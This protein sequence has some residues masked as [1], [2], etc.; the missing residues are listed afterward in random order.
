MRPRELVIGQTVLGRAIGALHFARP[1]Y[2]RPK[3]A[4][5]LFGAIHGD[6]PLGVLPCT[7]LTQMEQR[8]MREGDDLD[9]LVSGRI[10]SYRG[11]GYVLPTLMQ[12]VPRGGI[13][14][15]Q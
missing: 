13:N 15:L 2:A 6:E 7:L 3:P 11:R 5:V 4:A 12:L 10:Y 8:A 9:M 1:S 14:P